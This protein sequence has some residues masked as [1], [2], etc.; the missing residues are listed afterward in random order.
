MADGKLYRWFWRARLPGR[1]GQLCR[2]LRT[3]TLNSA[4]VEFVSDGWR[5]VTDRRAVRLVRHG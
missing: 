2:L 1:H 5:V 3:G 4:L